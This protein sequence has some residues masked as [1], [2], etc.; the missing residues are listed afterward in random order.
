M[1]GVMRAAITVVFIFGY[2]D[3]AVAILEFTGQLDCESYNELDW[4]LA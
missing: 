3:F 1:I 4:R 2:D